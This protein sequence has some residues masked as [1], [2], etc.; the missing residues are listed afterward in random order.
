MRYML[1][2]NVCIGLMRHPE[3]RLSAKFKAHSGELCV[4]TI[5]VHEL[6]HGAEKSRRPAYQRGVVQNFL[7]KLE[8]LEFDSL[9]ADHSGNIHATLAKAGQIIGAFDML[10]AGHARS[11]GLTVVTNN[12]R[13]FTRVEGLRC[14]DWLS[15]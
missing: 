12:L 7:S 3:G 11:L 13:E 1:D 15:A 9:A 14:E 6:I 10:I 2:S 8:V 4:S 5:T